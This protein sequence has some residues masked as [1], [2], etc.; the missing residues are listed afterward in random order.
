MVC[1]VDIGGTKIQCAV[2]TESLEQVSS[3]RLPTPRHD[4]A[5]FL[6]T[7]ADMVEASDEIAGGPQP[8][9]LAL[10]GVVDDR[11]LTVST[12][13]PCINGKRL[14]ADI[15]RSLGRPVAHDNDTRTFALSEAR[16]G[17]LDGA[18]IGLGVV[19][20]T[21]VAGA[22]C[23]DGRLYTSKR[24]I[25]GEYGHIALPPDLLAKYSLLSRK[26]SCGATGC[27]EQ[28]L[29]GPGLLQVGSCFGTTYGSVERLLQDMREG[30]PAAQRIF[31][32]YIDCLGYF[33][34]RLTLLFDPDIIAFGGGLSN[35][36]EIYARLPDAASAHLFD[37]LRA[38]PL[39]APRFGA[40]SGVRG[41]A[42][43]ALENGSR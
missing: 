9:G 38:P 10:P 37:G 40:E 8:V 31:D 34:S 33:V 23:L 42:I 4:Y 19:L 24:G 41:A 14:V 30:I 17:A 16:G 7:L 13:I 43:L 26:C 36:A 5:A 27:A 12:H 25:A 11:G 1:G 39:A 29:S 20:G 18:R 22:L 32:A 3:W 6:K 21:G 2:Y 28:V 15:E 35:V